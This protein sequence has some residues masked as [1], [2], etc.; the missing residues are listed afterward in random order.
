MKKIK[1]IIVGWYRKIF[2]KNNDLAQKR[3]SVCK[4]CPYKITICKQDI[5]NLCGCVL[6]AKTRVEDEQCYDNRW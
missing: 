6:S 2:N 4:V 3:L 1:N 5:C